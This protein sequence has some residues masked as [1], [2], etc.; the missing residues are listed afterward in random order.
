MTAFFLKESTH[1]PLLPVLFEKINVDE[2]D[3]LVICEDQV[4]LL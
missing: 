4:D 1:N 2:F 3:K